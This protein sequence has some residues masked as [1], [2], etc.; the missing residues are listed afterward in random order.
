M[1]FIIS[2]YGVA[3]ISVSADDVVPLQGFMTKDVIEFVAQS[4]TFNVKP[5]I[6]PGIPPLLMQ[7]LV[8]QSG[9]MIEGN[10]KFPILQ[11]AMIPNGDIVVASTTESA[12][13]IMN[14]FMARLDEAFGF[15]FQVTK[16]RRL[17]QSNLVV[18]FDRGLEEKI[19]ALAKIEKILNREIERPSMPF[20][21]KRLAFGHGDIK[22][23]GM[24]MALQSIEGGDFLIERRSSESYSDNRY[25]CSAPLQT[26]DH[27]RLLE[28]LEKEMC[29]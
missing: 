29:D 7:H 19:A 24:P 20:K 21:I 27:L 26:A 14:N 28:T 23:G 1:K 9:I 13:K 2:N 17:Y 6:P 3:A 8:F 10:D 15:R 5:N 22:P 4:Y 25:F 12:E 18:E 16:M 11:M